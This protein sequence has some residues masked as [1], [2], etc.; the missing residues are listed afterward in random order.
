MCPSTCG[1]CD[2]CVDSESRFKFMNLNGKKIGRD[3]SWVD[4]KATKQRCNISG[5]SDSCRETCGAC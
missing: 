5:V 2:S 1:T 3:C 4:N